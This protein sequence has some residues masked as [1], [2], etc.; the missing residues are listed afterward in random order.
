MEEHRSG[1]CEKSD[2]NIASQI[3]YQTFTNLH[4]D[5]CLNECNNLMGLL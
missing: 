2:E 3:V 1:S 5:A 4:T